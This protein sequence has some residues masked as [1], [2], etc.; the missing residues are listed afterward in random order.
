[1]KS[2]NGPISDLSPF[3]QFMVE[4]KGFDIIKKLTGEK[5]YK[6]I[7]YEKGLTSKAIIDR[8]P[9]YKLIERKITCNIQEI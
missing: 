5:I 7:A 8:N 6:F 3:A 4:L 9:N 1:M 2:Y